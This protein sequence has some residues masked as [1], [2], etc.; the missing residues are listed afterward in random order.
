MLC[1]EKQRK[2]DNCHYVSEIASRIQTKVYHKNVIFTCI[3]KIYA[4]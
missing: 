1:P 2:F 3:A 4:N